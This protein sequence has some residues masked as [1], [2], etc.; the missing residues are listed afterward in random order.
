MNPFIIRMEFPT[1][2][3]FENSYNYFSIIYDSFLTSCV[4]L[5][6]FHPAQINPSIE[7]IKQAMPD[8]YCQTCK[9]FV[10]TNHN[11]RRKKET[12]LLKIFKESLY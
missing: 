6:S 10:K 3:S 12:T 9:Y 1:L 5:F 7:S 11:F 4:S 8:L 2:K